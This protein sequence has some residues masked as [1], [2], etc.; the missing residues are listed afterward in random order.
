MGSGCGR[1]VINGETFGLV[2]MDQCQ[3]DCEFR[4]RPQ[5]CAKG[6]PVLAEELEHTSAMRKGESSDSGTLGHRSHEVQNRLI[7]LLSLKSL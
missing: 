4:L 1:Q 2:R 5:R 7:G 3:W 6:V